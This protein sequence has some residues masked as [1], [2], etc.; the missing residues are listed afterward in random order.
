MERLR[1]LDEVS[2]VRFASVYREFKDV[3]TFMKELKELKDK[4]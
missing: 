2:Y 1:S 3:D 4:R